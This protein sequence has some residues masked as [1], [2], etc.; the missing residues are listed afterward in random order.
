MS[1]A[2]G[3]EKSRKPRTRSMGWREAQWLS[4]LA[5]PVK[6]WCS[7]L[8]AM[9]GSSQLPATPALEDQTPSSASQAPAHI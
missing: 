8:S 9:S 5:A 7:V 4:V 1:I 3:Q 6:D 2:A